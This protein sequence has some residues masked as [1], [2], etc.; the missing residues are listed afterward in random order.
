MLRIPI[1]PPEP[2]HLAG[3]FPTRAV[4]SAEHVLC[5]AAVKRLAA[6][7]FLRGDDGQRDRAEGGRD[8]AR[9][10]AGVPPAGHSTHPA[11]GDRGSLPRQQGDGDV[12][13]Q[14]DGSLQLQRRQ[15]VG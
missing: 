11:L 5:D 8:L 13:V 4:T 15:T 10:V 2:S 7:A 6:V 9:V 1:P 12:A 3:I 14:K